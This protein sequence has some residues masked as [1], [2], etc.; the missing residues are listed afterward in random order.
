MDGGDYGSSAVGRDGHSN[1]TCAASCGLPRC[2]NQRALPRVAFG[3]RHGDSVMAHRIAQRLAVALGRGRVPDSQGPYRTWPPGFSF[4]LQCLHNW[5][6]AGDGWVSRRG[7]WLRWPRHE[8][9][10]LVTYLAIAG[11]ALFRRGLGLYLQRAGAA[12]R[13]E[14]RAFAAL[15]RRPANPVTLFRLCRGHQQFTL[16]I[17]GATYP[18]GL[19]SVAWRR[20]HRADPKGSTGCY[21]RKLRF[22]PGR[23]TATHPNGT[24]GP[25]PQTRRPQFDA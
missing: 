18:C 2:S 25:N 16:G 4:P 23:R 5:A 15:C 17:N 14:R 10:R 13:G 8:R 12:D 9:D 1:A 19:C 3:C 24:I 11:L 7:P 20:A 6:P 22:V 21:R